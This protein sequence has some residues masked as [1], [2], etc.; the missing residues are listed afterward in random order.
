MRK[1]LTWAANPVNID[2][3]SEP[4]SGVSLL[5]GHASHWSYLLSHVA[6]DS[7]KKAPKCLLIVRYPPHRMHDRRVS[8]ID[9][10]VF[11]GSLTSCIDHI[12]LI[13]P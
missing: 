7:R 3:L 13:L 6:S 9:R 12:T 4:V 10:A 1:P 8:P 2:K 5:T 11:P